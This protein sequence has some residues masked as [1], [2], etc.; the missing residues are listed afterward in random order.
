MALAVLRSTECDNVGCE[1]RFECCAYAMAC[2]PAALVSQL[3]NINDRTLMVALKNEPT[4]KTSSVSA[5][6]KQTRKSQK[7]KK[8]KK[9][10]TN[11]N[12]K[13]TRKCQNCVP[14]TIKTPVPKFVNGHSQKQCLSITHTHTHT[15]TTF[16]IIVHPSI[17]E[18]KAVIT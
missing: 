16:A 18:D 1:H 3:K 2:M 7:K 14:A 5:V 15:P 6:A 10:K 4:N 8:K 11:V 9:K 17:Q 13:Q 12:Q